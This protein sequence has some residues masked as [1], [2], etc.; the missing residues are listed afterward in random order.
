MKKLIIVCIILLISISI[1]AQQ[2]KTYKE[3]IE[4]GDLKEIVSKYCIAGI[5]HLSGE[6]WSVSIYADK[7]R[8]TF[9]DPDKASSLEFSGPTEILNYMDKYGW[10]Y[11]EKMSFN[12][13]ANDQLTL[14]FEK[15]EDKKPAVQNQSKAIAK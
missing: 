15:K 13:G 5:F 4:K 10:K 8:L 3:G 12:L 7:D 9:K 6:V 1:Y 14:L 2:V 11:I